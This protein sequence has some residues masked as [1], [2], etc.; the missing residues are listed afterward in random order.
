M[1][2]VIVMAGLSRPKDGVA[3]LAYVP[4]IHVFLRSQTWTPGT[5]LHS[6]RP[7]A[8]PGW[9][10]MT[11][12]RPARFMSDYANIAA[13]TKRE[14]AEMTKPVIFNISAAWDDKAAV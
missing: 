2:S 5:S 9:P 12:D 4:A 1:K 7:K 14:T 8:G 6:G 11:V 3:S 13:G 10:G